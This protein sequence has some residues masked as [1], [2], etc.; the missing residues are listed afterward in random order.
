MT[1]NFSFL[2]VYSIKSDDLVTQTVPFSLHSK[3]GYKVTKFQLD[4]TYAWH[5]KL[6]ANM[7]SSNGDNLKV[8]ISKQKWVV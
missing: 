8:T 3:L 2:A 5:L 1:P 7:A 4:P 6:L